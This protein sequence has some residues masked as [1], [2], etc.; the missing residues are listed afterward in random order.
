MEMCSHF[1]NV[2]SLHV[3]AMARTKNTARSNPFVLPRATLADHI[4]AIAVS[5]EMEKDLGTKEMG[6]KIPATVDVP[7][8]ENVE[9]VECSEIVSKEGEPEP[10]TPPGGDLY[11]PVFPEIMGQDIPKL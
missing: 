4:Q 7:E 6:S 3:V 5:T 11:T 2:I 9:S 8:I 1:K 10:M